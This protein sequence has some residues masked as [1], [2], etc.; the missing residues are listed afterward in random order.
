MK[1]GKKEHTAT[2]LWITFILHTIPLTPPSGPVV[3]GGHFHLVVVAV[4]RWV[5]LSWLVH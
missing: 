3:I 5:F 2:S 1:R 4:G